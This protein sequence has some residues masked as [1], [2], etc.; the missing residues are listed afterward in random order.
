M[1][2]TAVAI[3]SQKGSMNVPVINAL[4]PIPKSVS[5]GSISVDEPIR[6]ILSPKKPAIDV[7]ATR[8]T[9]KKIKAYNGFL[10]EK[11]S[12]CIE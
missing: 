11:L 12:N 6:G 9:T 1:H 3:A 10:Y 7:T 2:S 4:M 8:P 5:L